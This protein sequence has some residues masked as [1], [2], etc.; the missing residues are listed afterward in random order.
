MSPRR[1][2]KTTPSDDVYTMAEA[3]RLKGVSYHTVS[4]AVRRGTLPA[5]RL[6]RMALITA[7]DLQAWR[8][9]RERAPKKYRRREPDQTAVPALIDLASGERV[10][11]ARQL[12]LV[13]E[14]N[15]ELTRGEPLDAFLAFLAE[16]FAQALG[17]SRVELWTVD[18]TSGAWR[19]AAR[20]PSSR[21]ANDGALAPEAT[22]AQWL[23]LAQ[24]TVQVAPGGAATPTEPTLIVVPLRVGA[25]VF[26]VALGERD[27][28][29][30]ALASAQLQL[31]QALA[32]QAAL[33][34]ALD[35]GRSA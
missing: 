4:R 7:S 31:A 23:P 17:L 32:N 29:R 19:R 10:D 9:M 30:L 15:H 2:S 26:G 21:Q 3:A 25:D 14:T 24:A 27:G 22:L 35:R 13:I 11:L 8:P 20:F 33:A 5:Q 12:A 1:T 16:R 18:A 28:G 34:I 6:G